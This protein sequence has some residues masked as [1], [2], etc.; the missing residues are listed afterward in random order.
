M[1]N[2]LAVVACS[3]LTGFHLS[4]ERLCSTVIKSGREKISEGKRMAM[5]SWTHCS[6]YKKALSLRIL[7]RKKERDHHVLP[8]KVIE[9]TPPPKNL[10]IRCLPPVLLAMK[11]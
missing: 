11:E 8:Y 1:I 2:F 4:S 6:A 3:S 5:A 7:C 10:G 9:I